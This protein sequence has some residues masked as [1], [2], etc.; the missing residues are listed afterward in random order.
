MMTFIKA[1]DKRVESWNMKH[2]D[3]RSDGMKKSGEMKM[4]TS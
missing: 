3:L 1:Q 4:K 2:C